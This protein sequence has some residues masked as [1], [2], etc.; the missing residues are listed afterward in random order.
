MNMMLDISVSINLTVVI[1]SGEKPF[2]ALPLFSS[3]WT[4]Y[5]E[6]YQPEIQVLPSIAG[7]WKHGR[8]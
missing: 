2:R 7:L 6:I 3:S 5:V 4:V 8:T 1:L